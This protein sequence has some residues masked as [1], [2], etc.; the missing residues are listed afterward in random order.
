MS[1]KGVL[2]AE[3]V[4]KNKNA[5]GCQVGPPHCA[6]SMSMSAEGTCSRWFQG[7]GNILHLWVICL[8]KDV[9]DAAGVPRRG[10]SPQAPGID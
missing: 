4:W 2:E 1:T 9:F 7:P 10:S 3:K 5:V 8:K 6:A